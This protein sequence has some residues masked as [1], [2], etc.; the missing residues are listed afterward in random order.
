[1]SVREE[2]QQVTVHLRRKAVIFISMEN[3]KEEKRKKTSIL[4]HNYSVKFCLVPLRAGFA[5][6][7]AVIHL[8]KKHPGIYN[9]G[10]ASEIVEEKA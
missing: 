6:S 10:L 2:H 9:S 4:Q 8:N 7:S 5:S 3:Q 1:M